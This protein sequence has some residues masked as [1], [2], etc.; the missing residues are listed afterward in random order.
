MRHFLAL[1]VSHTRVSEELFRINSPSTKCM[2]MLFRSLGRDYA[3]YILHPTIYECDA[4][5]DDWAAENTLEAHTLEACQKLLSDRLYGSVERVPKL[6]RELLHDVRETVALRFPQQRLLSVGAFFILR[7]LVPSIVSP[8]EAGIAFA[9]STPNSQKAM[10]AVSVFLQKLA[11]GIATGKSPA[12]QTFFNHNLPLILDLFETVSSVEAGDQIPLEHPSVPVDGQLASLA[13]LIFK[14][15]DAIAR[16][17]VTTGHA[18]DVT[19]LAAAVGISKKHAASAVAAIPSMNPPTGLAVVGAAAAGAPDDSLSTSPTSSTIAITSAIA[20][21][22]QP[23]IGNSVIVGSAGLS[24]SS[25]GASK[26]FA[27][28]SGQKDKQAHHFGGEVMKDLDQVLEDLSASVKEFEKA[29]IRAQEEE[30]AKRRKAELQNMIL[31]AE[32]SAICRK[33]HVTPSPGVAR[34]FSNQSAQPIDGGST[35]DGLDSSTAT[36]FDQLGATLAQL[37]VSESPDHVQLSPQSTPSQDPG[38][39]QLSANVAAHLKVW[40]SIR[41]SLYLLRVRLDDPSDLN[42]TVFLSKTI[43]GLYNYI[44][45][46]LGKRLEMKPIPRQWASASLTPEKVAPLRLAAQKA[47]DE[48]QHTVDSLIAEGSPLLPLFDLQQRLDDIFAGF[49][50]LEDLKK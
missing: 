31:R 6:L 45:T 5:A 39:P 20:E 22:P 10:R 12:E 38:E 44:Q 23:S 47:I 1:E 32:I 13:E 35:S 19:K 33:Y 37:Q 15:F 30:M 9:E 18:I 7:F 46:P 28:P 16:Y 34:L 41:S 29:S 2:T 36:T 4:N 50:E 48:I 8:V 26:D 21:V 43:N 11:N 42:R 14:H 40:K 27:Q 17:A 3:Y 49:H 25:F 24:A